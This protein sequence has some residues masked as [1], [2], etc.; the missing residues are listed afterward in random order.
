[1]YA[2]GKG[3]MR[4][5]DKKKRMLTGFQAGVL[6]GLALPSFLFFPPQGKPRK[7]SA[8]WERVTDYLQG[9]FAEVVNLTTA[10]GKMDTSKDSGHVKD[11]AA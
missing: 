5:D 6:A 2:E 9:A 4:S 1:M 7:F 8:H 3:T 10:P 11:K